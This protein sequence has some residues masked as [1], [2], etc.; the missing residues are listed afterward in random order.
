MEQ[1]IF[2]CEHIKCKLFFVLVEDKPGV[3]SSK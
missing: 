2:F 1:W 3:Y